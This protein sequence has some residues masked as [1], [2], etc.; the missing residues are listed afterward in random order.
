[1]MIK[2]IQISIPNPCQENW[3]KMLPAEKGKFCSA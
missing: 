2:N 3:D 1:M